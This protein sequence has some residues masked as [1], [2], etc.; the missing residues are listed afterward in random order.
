LLI[1]LG[2]ETY[3]PPVSA[4]VAA[5]RP[6]TPT[7]PP[8]SPPPRSV[9]DEIE[10]RRRE[11]RNGQRHEDDIIIN[12]RSRSRP[13]PTRHRSLSVDERTTISRRP[14]PPP[15]IDDEADFY[16]R[17]TAERAY[18]GE[19]YNGATRDWAIIDVPPGTERVRMDG[20][21]GA[22]E[23]ITWQRY[24][25]VRRSRFIPESERPQERQPE[26]ETR[27]TFVGKRPKADTMWTE[28]TKDLVVK[29][30]IEGYGYEYEE[31]EWFFYVMEYLRY[32]SGDYMILRLG[33]NNPV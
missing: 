15:Q 32:V 33:A 25:G 17:K 21:G 12:H 19:A 1:L 18:I 29:E 13:A 22:S 9:Y 26:P 31:T 30:A 2:F 14:A 16:A 28:I 27:R 3:R 5:P 20:V 8:P 24:N 11:S 10:I 6:R 7:P 23:E 4:P